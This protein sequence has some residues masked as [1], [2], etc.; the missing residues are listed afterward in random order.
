MGPRLHEPVT[1]PTEGSSPR[2]FLTHPLTACVLPFPGLPFLRWL[3]S[4]PVLPVLQLILQPTLRPC[5]RHLPF[6]HLHVHLRPPGGVAQR[7][8]PEF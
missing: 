5:Q 2:A 3:P 1:P 4:E 7:P 6:P 8:Q